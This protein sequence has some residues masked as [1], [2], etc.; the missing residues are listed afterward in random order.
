MLGTTLSP[1]NRS[2]QERENSYHRARLLV[3]DE[4]SRMSGTAFS[5]R[6]FRSCYDQYKFGTK[7][8]QLTV[9]LFPFF[10]LFPQLL[11]SFNEL[12]I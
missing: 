8:V 1:L 9:R 11:S 4:A 7:F 5:E 6:A 12:I 2:W 3:L 10:Q